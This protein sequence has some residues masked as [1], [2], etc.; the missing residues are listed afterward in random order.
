MSSPSS[1]CRGDASDP[2]FFQRMAATVFQTFVASDDA[3]TTLL[4]LKRLHGLMPYFVLKGILRVSNPMAMI[5][6]E[7]PTRLSFSRCSSCRLF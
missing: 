4:Q 7:C 6:G 5:R 1:T 2:P 3:S